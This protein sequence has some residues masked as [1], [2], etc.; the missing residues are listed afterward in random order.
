MRKQVI[1]WSIL[2]F[3]YGLCF[4]KIAIDWG[5]RDARYERG[6]L[7]PTE[8]GQIYYPHQGESTLRSIGRYLLQLIPNSANDSK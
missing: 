7:S 5:E 6:G 4:K 2:L 3:T 8:Y 1:L